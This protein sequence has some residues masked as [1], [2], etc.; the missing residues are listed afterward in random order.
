MCEAGT[1]LTLQSQS[2]PNGQHNDIIDPRGLTLPLS[3]TAFS[4]HR[5]QPKYRACGTDTPP[6][7]GQSHP[8]GREAPGKGVDRVTK[9]T[10]RII[11]SRK[12]T[13]RRKR[14]KDKGASDR[15]IRRFPR[16]NKRKAQGGDRFGIRK[17]ALRE[18]KARMKAPAGGHG[19]VKGG[20]RRST[21]FF[22]A[23]RSI[24]GRRRRLGD[25]SKKGNAFHSPK[26]SFM[27]K[28]SEM[29]QEGNGRGM[30]IFVVW[31]S[32]FSVV[33]R[34]EG[35]EREGGKQG[36]MWPDTCKCFQG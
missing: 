24:P 14:K 18:E 28:A 35:K 21:D 2:L 15:K 23:L 26:V 9:T 30:L 27:E 16:R 34:R 19:N 29:G 36:R 8:C 12:T 22:I 3:N 33:A 11:R 31:I 4:S 32:V 7:R 20:E 25:E 17:K 6:S 1:A 10:G 13:K 5:N